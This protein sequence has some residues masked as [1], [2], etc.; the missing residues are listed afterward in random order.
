MNV[1]DNISHFS[2]LIG[3]PISYGRSTILRTLLSYSGN[4]CWSW[5]VKMATTT[6]LKIGS[7]FCA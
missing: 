6:E 2:N 3:M 7:F 1:D 4:F 5:K